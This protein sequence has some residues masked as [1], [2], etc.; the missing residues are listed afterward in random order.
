MIRL[1]LSAGISSIGSLYWHMVNMEMASPPNGQSLRYAQLNRSIIP[2]S[3]PCR[4]CSRQHMNAGGRIADDGNNTRPRSRSRAG[5]VFSIALT[6]LSCRVSSPRHFSLFSSFARLMR[7]DF[8]IFAV[9]HYQSPARIAD[10]S[11][12]RRGRYLLCPFC[13]FAEEFHC[14]YYY[15]FASPALHSFPILLPRL[16]HIWF[17]FHSD[18]SFSNIQTYS[19][20]PCRNSSPNSYLA[21]YSR[22]YAGILYIHYQF[23]RTSAIDFSPHLPI[24]HDCHSGLAESLSAQDSSFRA[25]IFLFISSDHCSRRVSRGLHTARYVIAIT[26]LHYF[27]HYRGFHVRKCYGVTR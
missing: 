17:F 1:P 21:L 23:Q 25:Y 2:H 14:S 6:R 10:I 7:F 15:E 18:A 27:S 12:A 5:W 16:L 4:K 20:L 24:Y 3:S 13:P 9:L 22:A 19:L 26:S 8:I 11:S